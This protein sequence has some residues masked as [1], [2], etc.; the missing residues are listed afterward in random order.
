MQNIVLNLGGF[1]I[2]SKF[3]TRFCPK[4]KEQ[5]HVKIFVVEKKMCKED[6]EF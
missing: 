3:R 4:Y 5:S 2:K 6:N 1:S